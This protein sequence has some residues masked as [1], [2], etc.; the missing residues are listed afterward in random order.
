MSKEEPGI[1]VYIGSIMLWPRK[2]I[3]SGW[4]LCDGALCPIG[5]Y[6]ALYSLIGTT[7]GGDGRNLFALP[8]LTG[9]FPIG[10]GSN[11]KNE[12]FILGHATENNQ[13]VVLTTNNLPSHDHEMRIDIPPK[14]QG[15]FT[16]PANNS[17]TQLTDKPGTDT[18]LATSTT[19]PSVPDADPY[20]TR[21]YTTAPPNVQMPGGTVSIPMQNVTV[22]TKPVGSGAA[23][24]IMPSYLALNF[25]ICHDG[26]FP[27]LT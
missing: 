15:E 6:Q 24:N 26:I 13:Q 4:L 7:Y 10:A 3:P 1:D 22:T 14:V 2:I 5:Q 25:I 19:N 8:N 16:I 9:R 18:V 12:M 23:L 17:S 27:N 11:T 20:Y 21:I